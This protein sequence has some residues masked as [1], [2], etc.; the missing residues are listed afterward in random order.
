MTGLPLPLA[1]EPG[2]RDLRTYEQFFCPNVFIYCPVISIARLARGAS[3]D[4]LLEPGA[5]SLARQACHGVPRLSCFE[6][7]TPLLT[8]PSHVFF[9]YGLS[10]LTMAIT[11]PAFTLASALGQ[12][13][14]RG[15]R[16]E[17]SG[18][19]GKNKDAYGQHGSPFGSVLP[20]E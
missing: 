11:W 8:T 17:C 7:K 20:R 4:G 16:N 15:N 10:S 19:C 6:K 12:H 3:S 9:R 13:A 14:L 2:I 5:R 1:D 18:A